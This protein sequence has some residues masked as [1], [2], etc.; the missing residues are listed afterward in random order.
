MAHTIVKPQ[1]IAE[2]AAT[3]LEQQ[4]VVPALMQREGI[5]KYKGA[6]NDTINVKV[7]GV[8][9]YRL[10]GWRNNRSSPIVFD[11]YAE[12]TVAVQFGGNIYSAVKLTDEQRDFDLNGWAELMTVQTEAVARGLEYE[13]VDTI[14]GASYRVTLGGA[15]SGRTLRGTLIKAREVMNKLRVPAEGRILLVGS[16][17]ESALLGDDKLVLASN[18]GDAGA[19]S[20]L[21][22]ATI[23]RL[24][25]FRIVTSNEMPADKAV[26]MIPSAFIFATG[27]P[28]VPGSVGAGGTAS[29]QGVAM[30]WIQDYDPAYL[31]D[32]SV[33]NTYKGFRAVKDKLIGRN[34]ANPDQAYVSTHEH[35]VRAIM[36]D[37]DATSDVTPTGAAPGDENDEFALITGVGTPDS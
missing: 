13:A 14:L 35:F 7:R 24:Y 21:R 15:V 32:R 3:A 19:V 12:T 27:A 17:W 25:G 22:D 26:A 37:L 31:Q 18:V 8:L 34:D 16:G 9:P 33:V 1:K 2:A 23:G 6:A 10:Y 11:E 36:L 20:A 5:D 4:L 29:Y 30:R 28:S